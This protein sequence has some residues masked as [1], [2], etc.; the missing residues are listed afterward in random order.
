MSQVVKS[1]VRVVPEGI[2]VF[3]A[4]SIEMGKAEDW[5]TVIER[6]FVNDKKV[7][8]LFNPRRDDWDSSWIQSIENEQF[9]I[10][11]NW[12]VDHIDLADFVFFYF[13]PKTKS[14]I[15]LMELGYCLGKGKKVVVC[16]PEGFWRKGNIE[17]MCDRHDVTLFT[18]IHSAILDLIMKVGRP[19]DKTSV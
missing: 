12:E 5:Q 9:N 14:P 3:L 17:I 8:Y 7:K 19:H 18:D 4:G 2:N 10:Q 11:V 13:D 16:C 15:T 1:P 6:F